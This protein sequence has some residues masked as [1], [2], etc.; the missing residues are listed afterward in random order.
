MEGTKFDNSKPR[1][2]LI[3]TEYIVKMS[4]AIKP[5]IEM[6]M[7]KDDE[8]V[9]DEFYIYNVIRSNIFRWK[10]MGSAGLLGKQ[11]PLMNAMIGCLMLAE[12]APDYSKDEVLTENSFAQRWDLIDPS[13]TTALANTYAYGAE[14][15]DDDNWQKVGSNRYYSA[16][17][18]HLDAYYSGKA[19][20]CESG[21]K[22][23]Y[24]AAWNCIALMWHES[25]EENNRIVS[26]IPDVIK[27]A[28]KKLTRVKSVKA[29]V[30]ATKKKKK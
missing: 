18:R 8:I 10:M 30:V 6:F 20:D 29:T 3:P 23:L 21:I 25:H 14:L 22:H 28:A 15:Y 7:L 13:W 9:L 26:E 5:F 24:H 11:H 2:D 19:Y 1:W 12:E 27:A 16:C 4:Q 17:N